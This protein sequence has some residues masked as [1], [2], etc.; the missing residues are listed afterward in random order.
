MG[1]SVYLTVVEP[2]QKTG[3]GIFVREN[4][5][6]VEISRE[7]WDAKFPDRVPVLVSDREPETNEVFSANYT[8]N[9]AAMAGEAGVYECV[10]RPEEIGITKAE[11][12]IE[13]LTKGIE[14]MESDPEQ[15]KKHNPPNGWG[16]YDTFLP[17][18]KRYR[19]ACV[20][21]PT[22]GVSVWR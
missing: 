4:G 22:A 9:C 1:V 12:L 10:W 17:W 13:P 14:L 8:H 5:Q 11:Q 15:F 18:L 2:V 6:T 20:E 16:S 7:E 19:D 3:S 21:Y